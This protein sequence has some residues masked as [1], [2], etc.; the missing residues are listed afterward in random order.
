MPDESQ[1]GYKHIWIKP[2]VVNDISWVQ[3]SKDTPYG[4]LKVR[5]EKEDASFVLDVQIPVGSSASVSLPFPVENVRVNG[6][7]SESKET[8]ELESGSYRI[9]CSL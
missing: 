8:L 1:P 6:Q 7:P 4:L 9:E 5:W 2:Q 3:A